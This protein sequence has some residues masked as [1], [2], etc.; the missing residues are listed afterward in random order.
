MVIDVR[1]SYETRIG[2]FKGAIDP[3][4]TAFREFPSWVEDSFQLAGTDSLPSQ[5]VQ[6]NN[7]SESKE[8]TEGC[9]S[10]P[11]VAM[12]CTGGIRCEKA[13]SYLLSKGFK[14]V[15]TPSCKFVLTVFPFIYV[16]KI[17]IELKCTYPLCI[18]S[19]CQL[20]GVKIYFQVGWVGD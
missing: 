17:T 13:S 16:L 7:R 10:P 18:S 14:E 5:E 1:N 3:C 19:A 4:T 15:M 9:K 8:E 12:Y 2:K 20:L 6:E 11:R